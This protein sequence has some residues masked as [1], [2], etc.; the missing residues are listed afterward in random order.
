[1]RTNIKPDMSKFVVFILSH[2]RPHQR[3]TYDLLRSC[4][5]T[6]DIIIVCDNEDGRIEEY[7]EQ[8][9][10]EHVYVFDK[11]LV[12]R[13]VDSMN[14]FGN[15]KA[16]LFARNACFDIARSLGYLYF[17]EL[18]DDYYYFGHHRKERAKKTK[19]YD[20]I[21]SWFIEFLL[22]AGPNVKTI[23]FSQ[24]GDHIGGYDESVIIKRKAMNSFF[25][26]VDRK[27][28]FMGILNEDVNAYVGG[29]IRGDLFFTFM[30]FQLDQ[31]DTQQNKGGISDLYLDVGTFVKSFYTIMVS[32]SS[33]KIALMGAKFTRLHHRIDYKK[34]LPCIIRERYR[35]D[36]QDNTTAQLSLF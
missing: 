3:K 6:G 15:R 21:A 22:N 2:G 25:C 33:V 34:T 20:L 35:H 13:D 36:C 26:L 18:D 16:I 8:Y 10:R 1:M 27:I 12:A 17:Q 29:G 30:P 23:A 28:D 19:K 5:Y 24:G 4:G 14:N 32:P 7:Y 9:G 31:D 11:A